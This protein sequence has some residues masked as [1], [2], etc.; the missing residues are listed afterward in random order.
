MA[1]RFVNDFEQP[2]EQIEPF[3]WL[4]MQGVGGRLLGWEG[5]SYRFSELDF[6]A[7]AHDGYGTNWP[8]NYKRLVPYYE[9]AERYLRIVG[10]TDNIPQLP[11]S[12]YSKAAAQSLAEGLIREP[13]A[14]HL[15]IKV[16]PARLSQRSFA[17]REQRESDER[18]YTPLGAIEQGLRTGRLTLRTGAIVT[19]L[20][21]EGNQV[22]GVQIV[23]GES[24]ISE[25]Y[26]NVVFLCASTLESTRLLLRCACLKSNKTLGRY[27][28][29]HVMGGGAFGYVDM[30][31]A[32]LAASK[33]EPQRIYIPRFRNIDHRITNGFIRGYGIQ[34]KV[35]TD[36]PE[37]C[38]A[39][40]SSRVTKTIRL[41]VVLSAFGEC[42]ARYENSVA[43]SATTDRWGRPNLAIGAR[44]CKNEERLM[45]DAATQCTRLLEVCGVKDIQTTSMLS[46]PGLAIHE[47]G[48]ARMGENPEESVVDPNC[49]AHA[50]RGLFVTDGACWVS[51]GCQNPT[52][53]MLA[54]TGMACEV[55]TRRFNL[56]KRRT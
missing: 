24:S 25:A 52:L 19:E 31:K 54:I 6:M 5:Q 47:V 23:E 4:R 8:I 43:L 18:G 7:R 38:L 12:I 15:G 21:V 39:E 17:K 48:T 55:V 28:M 37:E 26:A 9:E 30:P 56:E 41:R 14:K 2:Y 45:Q 44:W 11:D 36:S 3:A 1:E 13:A 53:T 33:R 51:S 50:V 35:I 40:K 10:T 20:I 34:G 22:R 16:I 49:E 29:D 27:L 42:L 46:T 32:A